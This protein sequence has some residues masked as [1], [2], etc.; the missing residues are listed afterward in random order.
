MNEETK[1][2]LELLSAAYQIAEREGNGTNWDGFKKSIEKALIPF[3]HRP[4][5]ART[6][7]KLEGD[8]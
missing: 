4:V 6:Y 3:N 2:I 1:E 5:T 8:K 7:R